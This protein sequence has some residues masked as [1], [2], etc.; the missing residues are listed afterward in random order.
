MMMTTRR[1]RRRGETPLDV[2]AAAL[3]DTSE[4]VLDESDQ[5]RVVAA[6]EAS[7]SAQRK[8]CGTFIGTLGVLSGVAY[9]GAHCACGAFGGGDVWARSPW[10]RYYYAEGAT[11]RDLVTACDWATAAAACASG[12]ACARLRGDAY[13]KANSMARVGVV[14]GFV[15]SCAWWALSAWTRG[16]VDVGSAVRGAAPALWGLTCAHIV[17]AQTDAARAVETLRSTM[18]AHKSL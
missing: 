17:R 16:T 4:R 12:L 18:Y 15:A 7:T 11:A 2:I 6:F 9:F 14:C 8:F 13:D 10:H 5:A 3:G 1:R